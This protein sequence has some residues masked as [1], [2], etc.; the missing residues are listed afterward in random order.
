VQLRPSQAS[1]CGSDMIV[2]TVRC[3]RKSLSLRLVTLHIRA[4][5]VGLHREWMIRA[6]AIGLSMATMRLIFVPTL[7]IMTTPTDAQIAMLSTSSS[8][9]A[10]VVHASA[11]EA[12]LR[13]TRRSGA[14]RASEVKA[15]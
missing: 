5:R 13:A 11:T 7:I 12:W 2:A 1:S 10:F 15:A 6:F 8:A 9:A 3:H 4:G 14:P